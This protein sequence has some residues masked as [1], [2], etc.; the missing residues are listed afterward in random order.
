[1]SAGFR[2]RSDRHQRPCSD[3]SLP[4]DLVIT[5]YPERWDCAYER[6]SLLDAIR[7]RVEYLNVDRE[8]ESDRLV[9]EI[10]KASAEFQPTLTVKEQRF[11]WTDAF[12]D[13]ILSVVCQMSP[14]RI[15]IS[16][17]RACYND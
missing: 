9:T 4:S 5:S 17:R 8:I 13:E 3:S 2:S 12:D 7:E 14:A 15:A 16:V 10:L 6:D 11:T 1:M